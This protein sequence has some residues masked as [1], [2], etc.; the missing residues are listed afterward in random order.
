MLLSLDIVMTCVY[1]RVLR[2]LI[3]LQAYFI[4]DD[5]RGFA[6]EFFFRLFM[7]VSKMLQLRMKAVQTLSEISYVHDLHS[8]IC[9]SNHRWSL[10]RM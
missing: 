1:A 3:F 9:T 7:L 6:D 4:K 8:N 5:R 10:S 2:Q